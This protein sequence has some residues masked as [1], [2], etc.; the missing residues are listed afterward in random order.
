MSPIASEAIT[1]H[2]SNHCKISSYKSSPS[3]FSFDFCASKIILIVVVIFWIFFIFHYK[4]TVIS[5]ILD[6]STIYALG[7]RVYSFAPVCFSVQIRFLLDLTVVESAFDSWYL[8]IWDLLHQRKASTRILI[9]NW[10]ARKPFGVCGGDGGGGTLAVAYNRFNTSSDRTSSPG[11]SLWNRSIRSI[12]SIFS[13]LYSIRNTKSK[14]TVVVAATYRCLG[15]RSGR[16]CHGG[17]FFGVGGGWDTIKGCWPTGV[18]GCARCHYYQR[19]HLV[20]SFT[21][22]STPPSGSLWRIHFIIS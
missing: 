19:K 5:F 9:S 20:F 17:F 3:V 7:E 8:R 11:C 10:Q 14:D 4:S 2:S 13:G 22:S 15:R 21:T 16:R 1:Q 6:R 18:T 12:C